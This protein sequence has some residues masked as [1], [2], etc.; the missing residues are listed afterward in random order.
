MLL[1]IERCLYIDGLVREYGIYIANALEIPQSYTN[2][3]V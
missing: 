1:K 3:L 2:P